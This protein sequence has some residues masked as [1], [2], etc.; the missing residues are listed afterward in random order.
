MSVLFGEYHVTPTGSAIKD[1]R[2]LFPKFGE[3]QELRRQTLKLAFWP[4]GVTLA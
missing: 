1:A 4:G 3:Y 2:S